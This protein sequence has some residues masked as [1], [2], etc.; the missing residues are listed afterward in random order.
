MGFSG[1]EYNANYFDSSKSIDN[2]KRDVKII[3]EPIIEVINDDEV[4]FLTKIDRSTFI[5]L[6]F[7]T[8]GVIAQRSNPSMSAKEVKRI[9]ATQKHMV[10]HANDDDILIFNKHDMMQVQKF[11]IP[12]D[13]KTL[14]ISNSMGELLVATKKKIFFF[15]L[16]SYED[17]IKECIQ[18]CKGKEAL[19]VFEAYYSKYSKADK[20][21][22]MLK[23]LNYRLG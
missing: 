4:L 1:K 5:G 9:L 14:R 6:I 10:V 15:E 3:D 22:S 17:Q 21:D 23:N 7:D 19:S 20:R 18:K 16:Q 11:T 13:K 8:N 2:I 12:D